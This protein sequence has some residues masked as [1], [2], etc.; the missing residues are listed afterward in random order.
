MAHPH[1]GQIPRRKNRSLARL[2]IGAAVAA[3]AIACREPSRDSNATTTANTTPRIVTLSPSATEVVAALGATAWLV[4]VDNY[5]AFPPEVKSLAS[6]GNYIAPNLEMIIRLRPT[7]VIVDDVHASQ[8]AALH[9]RGVATVACAIHGLG[10][11]KTALATIGA[12]IGTAAQATAAIADIDAALRHHAAAKPAHRPRILAVIDRETDGLGNLIAA[13]PGSWI[14]ELLAVVGGDNA[15]AAAG[16][17]YPKISAEEV[18]RTSPEIILDL[19]QAARHSLAPWDRVD[20]PA[21]RA[22]R[23]VAVSDA[24]LV[25]PS[26]RVTQALDRLA[27]LIRR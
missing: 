8:A 13:G 10:D 22:K 24:Y 11:V 5:S 9:D 27:A 14:D 6:V 23:V 21:V 19:S 16:T 3:A 4:G 1:C 18:L 2:A 7:L 17:R 20:V 25:A 15:V 26:P 12:R